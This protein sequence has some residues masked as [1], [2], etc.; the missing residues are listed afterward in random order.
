MKLFGYEITI[1][2]AAQIKRVP[3]NPN[4]PPPPPIKQA[5]LL[6]DEIREAA[7]AD[8]SMTSIITTISSC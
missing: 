2:K 5:P 7:A 4:P 6:D 3:R 1:T 8:A